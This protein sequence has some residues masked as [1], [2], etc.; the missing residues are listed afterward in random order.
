MKKVFILKPRYPI[1][2]SYDLSGIFRIFVLAIYYGFKVYCNFI[3]ATKH[4]I[5]VQTLYKMMRRLI[6]GDWGGGQL[7]YI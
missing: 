5:Q 7:S 6:Y 2:Y 3:L 4:G 1:K